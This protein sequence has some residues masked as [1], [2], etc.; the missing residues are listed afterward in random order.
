MTVDCRWLNI[1]T[2]LLDNKVPIKYDQ[3]NMGSLCVKCTVDWHCALGMAPRS[4]FYTAPSHGGACEEAPAAVWLVSGLFWC[5]EPCGHMGQTQTAVRLYHALTSAR[6]KA[7]WEKHLAGLGETK[8][9]VLAPT[10][11]SMNLLTEPSTPDS[12]APMLLS[13]LPLQPLL[14]LMLSQGRC[15]L[16]STRL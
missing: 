15:L 6:S 14:L 10:A 8:P 4:D 1:A 2:A 12:P 9:A 3:H 5:N 13:G 11:A 7:C 16:S